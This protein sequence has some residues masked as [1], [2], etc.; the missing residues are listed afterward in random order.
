MRYKSL[1]RAV[2]VNEVRVLKHSKHNRACTGQ[3][4]LSSL[5]LMHIHNQDKIVL[6]EVVIKFVCHQTPTEAGAQDY[7]EG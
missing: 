3:E 6:D 2:T 4:R 7:S 1:Q 5:A